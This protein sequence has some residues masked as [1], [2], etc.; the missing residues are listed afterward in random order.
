MYFKCQAMFLISILKQS[1]VEMK[2][3]IDMY[4]KVNSQLYS[5]RYE[6]YRIY[7]IPVLYMSQDLRGLNSRGYLYS[8]HLS[9]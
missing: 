6:K 5:V 8:L 2:T 4:T 9:P 3:A 7:Q 1:G